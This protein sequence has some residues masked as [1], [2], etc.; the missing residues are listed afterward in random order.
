MSETQKEMVR[1]ARLRRGCGTRSTRIRRPFERA[2][3]NRCHKVVAERLR[4][5]VAGCDK[6]TLIRTVS[7]LASDDD[8]FTVGARLRVTPESGFA[9]CLPPCDQWGVPR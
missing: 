4:G 3:L 8:R 7:A 2:A 9:E 1:L 6:A 5:L